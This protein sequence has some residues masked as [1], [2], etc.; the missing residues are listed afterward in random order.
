MA[1][2]SSNASGCCSRSRIGTCRCAVAESFISTL[3]HEL[4]SRRRWR[5]RDQARRDIAVWIE[6]WYN[7]RW[8]HSTSNMTSPTDYE[9]ANA[10]ETNPS[11]SGGKLSVRPRSY[12]PPTRHLGA[13]A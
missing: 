4:T 1:E 9:L 6:T 7:R 13:Q 5:T 8:L 2:S 11:R 12:P 3:Q 10:A